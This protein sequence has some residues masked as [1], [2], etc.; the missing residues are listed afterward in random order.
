MYLQLPGFTGA[1]VT[2]PQGKDHKR[3]KK[4]LGFRGSTSPGFSDQ[5]CTL[6]IPKPEVT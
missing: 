5:L 4:E 1:E 3:E 6:G 2:S